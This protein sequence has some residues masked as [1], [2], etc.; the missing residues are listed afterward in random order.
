MESKY[1][2]GLLNNSQPSLNRAG[3]DGY[4]VTHH[5]RNSQLNIDG[6][7]LNSSAP[8]HQK[9]SQTTTK[10]HSIADQVELT[11]SAAPIDAQQQQHLPNLSPLYKIAQ[12]DEPSPLKEHTK[13]ISQFLETYKLR[14]DNHPKQQ[15]HRRDSRNEKEMFDRLER[16]LSSIVQV[17]QRERQLMKQE[18]GQLR[19][20]LQERDVLIA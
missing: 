1:G 19:Q 3:P 12:E 2:R 14:G 20:M 16:E 6:S 4:T 11:K 17:F 7:I 15:H 13:V 10:R 9:P 5:S 18:N 8:P